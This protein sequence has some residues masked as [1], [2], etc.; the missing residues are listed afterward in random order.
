MLFLHANLFSKLS[1]SKISFIQCQ[2][3]WIQIRPDI[4]S[5]LIWVQTVC[6]SCHQKTLAGKEL[7]RNL[8]GLIKLMTLTEMSPAIVPPE[9][10]DTIQ[11]E[12]NYS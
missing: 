9:E 5:G 3:V 6:K 11:L 4:L 7:I 12:S 8:N 1:F 2:T 10:N